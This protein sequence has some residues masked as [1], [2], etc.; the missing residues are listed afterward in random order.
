MLP[1]EIHVIASQ[2]MA[3]GKRDL[4]EVMKILEWEVVGRERT[5]GKSFRA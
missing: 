4:D 2:E 5:S 1:S 3:A